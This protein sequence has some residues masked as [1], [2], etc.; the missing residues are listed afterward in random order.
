MASEKE[1]REALRIHEDDLIRRRNVQGLGI[2]SGDAEEDFRVVA[3]VSQ[4]KPESELLPEDV[5]PKSLAI[6]TGTRRTEVAVSVIE[7]GEFGIE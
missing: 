2:Q 7:A 3:Y 5:L 6:E 1:A 4:K